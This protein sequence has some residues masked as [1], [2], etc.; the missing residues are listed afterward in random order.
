MDIEGVR[1]P[2]PA[3]QHERRR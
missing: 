1:R 2:S 3:E